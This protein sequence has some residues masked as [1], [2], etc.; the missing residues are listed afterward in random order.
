MSYTKL[1]KDYCKAFKMRFEDIHENIFIASR[2]CTTKAANTANGVHFSRWEKIKHRNADVFQILP[3]GDI[4]GIVNYLGGKYHR[5]TTRFIFT[6]L[7]LEN[8][9]DSI[10]TEY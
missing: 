7:I 8:I 5:P 1:A 10:L 9:K 4:V 6:S 2:L 3:D